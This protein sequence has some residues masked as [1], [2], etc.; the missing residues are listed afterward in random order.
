MRSGRSGSPRRRARRRPGPGGTKAGTA[1]AGRVEGAAQLEGEP[2]AGPAAGDVVVQVAVQ[3]LELGVEV[4]GQGD[5]QD[6]DVEGDEV[7]GAGEAAEAQVGTTGFGGVG[8]GLDCGEQLDG[9]QQLV[10]GPARGTLTLVGEER[11]PRPGQQPVDLGVGGVQAPEA[12][13]RIGVVAP[14]PPRRHPDPF[15]HHRQA[16]EQVPDR[17][18]VGIQRVWQPR[19]GRTFHGRQPTERSIP[20]QG[21]SGCTSGQTA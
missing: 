4:G 2:D 20:R 3:A 9:G 18:G 10:V 7:E 12:V 19:V 8:A 16:S 13:A 17:G 5:E 14:P 6:L 15:L 1:A 11:Q 21:P